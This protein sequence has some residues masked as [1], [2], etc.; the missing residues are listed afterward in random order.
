MLSKGRLSDGPVS[1]GRQSMLRSVRI[2]EVAKWKT[3]ILERGSDLEGGLVR[4]WKIFARSTE[5]EVMIVPYAGDEQANVSP[6]AAVRLDT[7]CAFR[8]PFSTLFQQAYGPTERHHPMLKACF[9]V[10]D[11]LWLKIEG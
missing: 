1:N 9:S 3:K 11:E 4:R 8:T 10:D 2:R 5:L 7:V 6:T